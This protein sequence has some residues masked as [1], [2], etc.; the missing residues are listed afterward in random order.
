M[1]NGQIKWSCAPTMAAP[2]TCPMKS[3]AYARLGRAHGNHQPCWWR[4]EGVLGGAPWPENL[5]PAATE[6]ISRNPG[7]LRNGNSSRAHRGDMKKRSACFNC[8]REGHKAAQCRAGGRKGADEMAESVRDAIDRAAGSHI[9]AAEYAAALS[10]AER[11]LE[12]VTAANEKAQRELEARNAALDARID[13]TIQRLATA[14]P[15]K[16]TT[17]AA[18]A[19]VTPVV[20]SLVMFV[21]ILAW[22]GL[23]SHSG[24]LI[25][26]DWWVL[27]PR[28]VAV[29]AMLWSLCQY[30]RYG[31][32]YA[33]QEAVLVF[34][35]HV[36][37]E[38]YK[39]LRPDAN[40]LQELKHS[41]PRLI[42]VGVAVPDGRSQDL[43]VSAELLAQLT[44]PRYMTLGLREDQVWDRLV[45]GAETNQTVNQDRY[46]NMLGQNVAMNT[47][48]VA[49]YLWRQYKSEIEEAGFQFPRAQ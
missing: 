20:L 7:G 34:R 29:L 35:R 47:A 25:F 48:L 22:L 45:R 15:V 26:E 21:E 10:E 2:W 42:E 17:L 3:G 41:N 5:P 44:A 19:W 38:D 11:S 18:Y 12:K 31:T 40:A 43:L 27:P 24:S 8:G 36:P 13:H 28:C 14:T 37:L 30:L 1:V 39:D 32:F 23:R 4:R 46:R 6:P 49:L 16:K 33:I 9:A